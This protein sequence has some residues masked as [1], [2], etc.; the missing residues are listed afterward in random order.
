[1]HIQNFFLGA[2]LSALLA[3]T[4]TGN[5]AENAVQKEGNAIEAK[6]TPR[7]RKLCTKRKAAEKTAG[8]GEA[9]EEKGAK[10]QKEAKSLK[11]NHS[12]AAEGAQ[13][14]RAGA[15]EKAKGERM[16]KSAKSHKEHAK[17]TQKASD[18]MD[19][20]GEKVEKAGTAIDKK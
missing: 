5:A 15:G 1:M 8:A 16:E 12:T 3:M 20:S 18:V 10:M 19:K 4:A 6:A 7:S 11:K 2:S 13:L 9:K 17:R 14:D